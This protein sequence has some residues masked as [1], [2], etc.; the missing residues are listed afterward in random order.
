MER[1]GVAVPLSLSSWTAL[2]CSTVRCRC[3]QGHLRL[4]AANAPARRR[5][6]MDVGIV[7]DR[8]RSEERRVGALWSQPRAPRQPIVVRQQVG[9][10]ARRQAQAA[11]D[12]KVTQGDNTEQHQGEWRQPVRRRRIDRS[13][14]APPTNTGRGAVSEPLGKCWQTIARAECKLPPPSQ[15]QRSI[16]SAQ[17]ATS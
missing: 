5:R 9:G 17:N 10:L 8:R 6:H 13:C 14:P 15:Q 11:G 12:A 4:C 1:A 7:V 3:L 2:R 16:S